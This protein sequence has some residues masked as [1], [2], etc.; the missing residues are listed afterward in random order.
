M[1]LQ[2]HTGRVT[3]YSE[4]QTPLIYLVSNVQSV[5]DAKRKFVF[6]DGHGIAAYSSWY[7]SVTG[8]SKI[9]WDIVCRRYWQDIDSDPD[10]QRRKQ[11]EFLVHRICSW[12]LIEKIVVINK[13]IKIRVESIFE[14]FDSQLH[15]PTEIKPE[16]YY[17]D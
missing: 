2:L 7:N 13:D 3:N 10:R 17:Y 6:S 9:D 4:G 12:E 14:R 15:I 5:M 11:A 1:M 16:W 8:L